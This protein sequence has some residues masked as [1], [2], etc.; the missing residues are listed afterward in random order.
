MILVDCRERGDR[1]RRVGEVLRFEKPKAPAFIIAAIL[2]L[3]PAFIG[4]TAMPPAAVPTL[5]SVSPVNGS[6]G[7]TVELSTSPGEGHQV[8]RD[9]EE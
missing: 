8:P 5:S 2:L 9:V 4:A 6:L 7:Q 3:L 1:S